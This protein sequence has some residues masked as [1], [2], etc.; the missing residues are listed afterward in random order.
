MMI[1]AMLGETNIDTTTC[2]PQK[3]KR[4]SAQGSGED[5]QGQASKRPC[6]SQGPSTVEEQ[7]A[8][9]KDRSTLATVPEFA[10]LSRNL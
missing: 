4:D 1:G 7:K 9:A 8:K 10:G 2:Q 5:S 6:L 3:C